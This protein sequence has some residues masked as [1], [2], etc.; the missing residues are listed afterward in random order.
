[1][2]IKNFVVKNGLTVGNTTITANTGNAV[3]GNADL[4]NLA[5]ANFFQ[6]NGNALFNIQGANVVGT[7]PNA[8]MSA[9][10]GNVTVNAQPNITSV[11][12]LSS[13]AVSGNAN[14]GGILTDNYYYA[15]GEPVDF[16]QAAGSNTQIQFNNQND[17]GASANFTFDTA[18]NTLSVAG[19]ANVTTLNTA[20]VNSGSS[21][22]TITANTNVTNFYANG[23]VAFPANV[24]APT[25]VGNVAGNITGNI[26]AAGANTEIQFN[27]A[28][29]LGGSNAFTFNKTSNLLTVGG[30][31][32]SENATLGNLAT[33]NY[34][35]VSQNLAVVGN[36]SGGNVAGGNLV[37]ANFVTGTLTTASQPNITSVGTLSSLE[38]SGNLGAGNVNGGNL[39]T[40]NFLAGTLTT[41]AQPNITSVGNLSALE[42]TG[43]ILTSANI[44]TD[45][46]IGRTSG[47]L[48][49]ATGVDQDIE[50]KPSGTGTVDVWSK[51]ISNVATPVAS[52]DAATKGYVDAAVEG[53]HIH[54]PC[55]A[56]T[57][58]TLATISSGTVTYNN[59]TAGVGATLTTTGSYTTID[60]VNIAT[61]GTRILVKNEANAAHNGI[62]TYTSST[63]LTRATD[64]DTPTEM[65]GGD[66]T[67]V[68]NGTLY[69]DTGWVMT[70][71][72]TTVGTSPVNWLQFSGAGEYTAGTGLTLN[73]TEFSISNTTVTAGAYGNGDYVAT[74]TVNAQGQLT[75]A[76][77]TAITAN[78]ANLSGTTLNANIVNSSLTSVGTL[79]SLSVSGN[80]SA[81]NVNAGNLL[82]ANFVAGTLTTAAQPNITSVGSLTD[83]TV[84]GN[85]GAGNVN[86]GNLLTANFVAGTL[87]TA[88]QPNITSVGNLSSLTV[89]GN[90]GAANVAGG[91]LVS[92]NFL[93]GTLT[94]A[95]QP[96]ITSV[97]QLTSLDVSGNAVAGNL[98][99]GGA[100]SVTGNANIGNIGTAQVLATANITTP[101]VIA[102]VANG[103]SPFVI[104][105]QTIVANLNADLLDGYN[106]AT[107]N[108]ANTVAVRNSDGNLAANYFIGNGAFLTGIDTSLIA[109]GNSNVSVSAN[110]NITLSV[111]GNSAVAVFTGTG[112]NIN[113]YANVTGNLSAGNVTATD[114]SGTTLGG[115]LTTASQPNV[116]SVGTL[117]SLAVTGTTTSGNIYAN[118][119]TVGANLL[120]GTL[121]TAAQPNVTSVG[122]LTSL[123]IAANGNITMSGAEATLSGANLVS[124]TLLTGT[125]TTAAQPNVTS[126]GTLSSITTSG[127][128][129]VGGNV[130]VQVGI[131][132][133]RANI[134]VGAAATV[135][136]H[137]SPTDWRTAKYVISGSGDDGFQSVETLLVH[138]GVDSYITIYGS[139]CSNNT[140]DLITLSSNINGVTGNVTVYAVSDSDNCYVNLVSSYIKT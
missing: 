45:L 104:N 139:I 110:G 134:A 14:V 90:L 62:Y 85:V 123:T 3:F 80:A 56:A 27:D 112:A 96:N 105:S 59:G 93:A 89:T 33:A 102:N 34:V 37:S 79:G 70:D 22:L 60:G 44:V 42:V 7:V 88:A 63:V 26:A 8:N 25:F 17:F 137:F 41:A 133:N 15:N 126:V 75:A 95:A 9:Y 32:S 36:I 121:T 97:G 124:A 61:V 73:G 122:N 127:N 130:K 77:N 38:V 13:L 58:N 135:I 69:N 113:G 4:G 67:F 24:S 119:G 39:V 94:T 117:S 101:Q 98:S 116:T 50:L 106:T 138:D 84:T 31:I 81:G 74:F 108:A 132:S 128:A 66:F 129:V 11:G 100:L 71:P 65:A 103:T 91:N 46:I 136:D 87:T 10:A 5:I 30:N 109:N 107:S 82:T 76:A 47:I 21:A 68:Q 57:P 125:L 23:V 54:A 64:F 111:A 53:L 114:V 20:N 52:T 55:A 19:N 92:A 18:T 6:G 131:T 28:G 83:L 72:V 120:A 12:T 115:T 16:Q 51:I 2:A 35:N 99:T 40:A 43:N 1:M 29:L 78:A 140:S 118:S 48:I 86:A 49:T